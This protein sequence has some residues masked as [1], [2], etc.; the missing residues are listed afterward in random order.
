MYNKIH[1]NSSNQG[2]SEELED[3]ISRIHRRLDK[4]DERFETFEKTMDSRFLELESHLAEVENSFDEV[5]VLE[6]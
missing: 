6:E 1:L 3:I 2:N 4:I 5:C